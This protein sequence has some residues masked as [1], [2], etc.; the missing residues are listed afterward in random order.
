VS[1]I[2]ETLTNTKIPSHV[3]SLVLDFTCEDLE[4]NDIEDVP[5][6]RYTFR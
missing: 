1:E 5:Y 3:R 6:I 4:G 2:Y